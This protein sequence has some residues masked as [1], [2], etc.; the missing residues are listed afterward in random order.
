MAALSRKERDRR[1]RQEDILRAAEHIFAIKGYHEASIQDIAKEAQYAVGTV[2]LYFKDKET[3]YTT[4]VGEKAE[5]LIHTV[6]DKVA[7]ASGARERIKVLVEEHLSYFEK[8]EDFFR[9]YFAERSNLSWAVKGRISPKA[10]EKF[11]DYLDYVASLLKTG[12]GEGVVRDD[13]SAREM[14]SILVSMLNAVIIPW[15]RRESIKAKSSGND[16][17]L[18]DMA[19]FILDMFFNGAK[20]K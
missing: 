3:L 2:Y 4:L 19:V 1:L 10:M 16:K 11:L 7:R 5:E 15:L 17:D 12:Q 20:T 6:K 18:K 13:F 9:I 8:N 14:S